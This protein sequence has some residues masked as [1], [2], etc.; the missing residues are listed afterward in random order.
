MIILYIAVTALYLLG[1]LYLKGYGE[2]LSGSVR[3]NIINLIAPGF[4]SHKVI[5][6]GASV[7]RAYGPCRNRCLFGKLAGTALNIPVFQF[8]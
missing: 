6:G 3:R 4:A 5:Q 1:L 8:L 7:G 2:L